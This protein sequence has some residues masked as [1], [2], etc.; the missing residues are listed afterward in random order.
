MATSDRNAGLLLA[1]FGAFVTFE[2][3]RMPRFEK[4]GGSLLNSP[5]LVPGMLGIIICLLGLAMVLRYFLL[6]R[7]ARL[8]GTVAVEPDAGLVAEAQLA[9]IE[10]EPVDPPA[11]HLRPSMS[12]LLITLALSVVFAGVL[13]GRLPFWLAVFLFVA[14]SIVYYERASLTSAARALRIGAIAVAIAGVTAFA[15]PFVFERIFLVTLP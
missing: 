2:A 6:H 11:T 1:L 9:E 10:G 5:G 8:R 4:I 12:R 7:A 14:G 13:V 15:V 3:W